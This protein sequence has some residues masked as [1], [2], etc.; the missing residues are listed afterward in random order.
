MIYQQMHVTNGAKFTG[1]GPDSGGL[2]LALLVV[3][4]AGACQAHAVPAKGD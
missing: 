1:H 3:F 4:G 2:T